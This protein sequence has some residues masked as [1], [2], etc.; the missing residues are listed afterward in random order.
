MTYQLFKE[1]ISQIASLS[2]YAWQG[3]S[4]IIKDQASAYSW[5]L[6]LLN[7]MRVV[8]YRSQVEPHPKDYLL[9][10]QSL[11]GSL[12]SILSG[13]EEYI[14]EAV[15]GLLMLWI[16]DSR[17]A[18][19]GQTNLYSSDQILSITSQDSNLARLGSSSHRDHRSPPQIRI[20]RS[21]F[22]N[23]ILTQ[24]SQR[25]Y[26]LSTP[27]LETVCDQIRSEWS[28]AIKHPELQFQK[29]KKR[30][31]VLN[32]RQVYDTIH[33]L[34]KLM[35]E[36]LKVLDQTDPRSIESDPSSSHPSSLALKWITNLVLGDEIQISL[37]HTTGASYVKQPRKR[38]PYSPLRLWFTSISSQDSKHQF[39]NALQTVLQAWSIHLIKQSRT[40]RP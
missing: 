2:L 22:S 26:E 20:N 17:R 18:R 23:M 32:A 13:R 29:V 33:K 7:Q 5:L 30:G 9:N 8:V 12:F 25:W 38:N 15:E 3:G 27:F 34:R 11:R 19:F 24:E 16:K 14:P 37:I 35:I 4:E 28:K 6:N 31:D 10:F 36:F 39:Q 21:P 1:F 40:T